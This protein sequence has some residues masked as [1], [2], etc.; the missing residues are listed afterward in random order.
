MIAARLAVL[1]AMLLPAYTAHLC[2]SASAHEYELIPQFGGK[3]STRGNKRVLV[4]APKG[5]ESGEYRGPTWRG[6]DPRDIDYAIAFARKGQRGGPVIEIET[7]HIGRDYSAKVTPRNSFM[8]VN[9]NTDIKGLKLMETFD[10]GI[11]GK[12]NVWRFGTYNRNYLLVLIVQPDTGG[13]TEVDVYLSGENP[14][15]LTQCLNSLKE[16]ARSIRI[17][18]R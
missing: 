8:G 14:A 16:V 7:S 3:D 15:Q 18:D 17:V 2:F 1:L 13:R 10:A 4:T 11:N 6:F 12:L 5:W 9:L